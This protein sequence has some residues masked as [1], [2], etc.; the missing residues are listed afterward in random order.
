M[1]EHL[2]LR[3]TEDDDPVN[4]ASSSS[5]GPANRPPR[6]YSGSKFAE[7]L[8][9]GFFRES[10]SPVNMGSLE[11]D[12]ETDRPPDEQRH[13][14]PSTTAPM[15]PSFYQIGMRMADTQWAMNYQVRNCTLVQLL[16][17]RWVVDLFLIWP[18][19]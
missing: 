18:F 3:T 9:F 16:A 10:A 7:I 11:I 6:V 19:L 12:A 13:G 4:F 15:E 17:N 5:S 1:E 2:G 14:R 8:G